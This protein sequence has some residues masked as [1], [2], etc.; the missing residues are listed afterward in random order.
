MSLT[1]ISCSGR[2][3]R[4]SWTASSTRRRRSSW[5]GVIVSGRCGPTATSLIERA[6][7]RG[8]R[9]TNRNPV[10]KTGSTSTRGKHVGMPS[11]IGI[12]DTMI[13]FPHKDM[14]ETYAFITRQTKDRESKED[15]AFPAQ[16]MFKNVP[17]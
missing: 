3:A 4:S 16:Y 1:W 9:L 11:D 2:S 6:R 7:Y 10:L 12:I 13:G 15:F 14:K 8:A 17:E 5:R